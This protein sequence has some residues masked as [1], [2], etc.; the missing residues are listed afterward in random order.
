MP[1]LYFR[2]Q[3]VQ[4]NTRVEHQRV[5]WKRN[6]DMEQNYLKHTCEQQGWEAHISAQNGLQVQE[7]MLVLS[8]S[9]VL[10]TKQ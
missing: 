5:L 1:D 4:E 3:W 7:Y 6:M 9:Y 2:S 10:L 8:H